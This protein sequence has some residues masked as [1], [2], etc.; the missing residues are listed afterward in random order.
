MLLMFVKQYRLYGN[1]FQ[2]FSPE[3]AITRK[4]FES[5]FSNLGIKWKDVLERLYESNKKR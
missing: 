3:I 4:V 5:E 2:I 1:E